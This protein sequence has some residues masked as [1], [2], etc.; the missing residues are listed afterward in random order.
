[1]PVGEQQLPKGNYGKSHSSAAK[2]AAGVLGG[3]AAG[4]A[5]AYAA[6]QIAQ[7]EEEESLEAQSNETVASQTQTK[8][9][10]APKPAAKSE[11]KL[12]PGLKT[13]L[14]EVAEHEDFL[15]A[16][17]VKITEVESR[18]NDSG[19]TH[20]YAIGTVDGHKAVFASTEDGKVVATFIDENDNKIA[21]PQEI[22]D[23]RKENLTM[24]SL[25]GY[26]QPEPAPS[27][28]EVKIM[29]EPSDMHVNVQV[30]SM[31]MEPTEEPVQ[32]IST[33]QHAEHTS[34]VM[35]NIYM[36]DE[37][38]EF[39]DTE[40]GGSCSMHP[41]VEDETPTSLPTDN[42]VVDLPDYSNNDDIPLYDI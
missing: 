10:A 16:H 22:F 7:S 26:T 35:T 41:V 20:E 21:E 28:V 18:V 38:R 27:P 34:V 4:A 25:M 8:E 29:G 31:P 23:L 13:Q 9:P 3:V 15:E 17:D 30:V 14:K 37:P 40:T 33:P 5:G 19:E 12:E 32:V 2:V 36:G 11:P 6:S 42:S 39:E 1:M 24:Q